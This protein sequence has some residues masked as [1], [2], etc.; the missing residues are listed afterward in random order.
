V[1]LP[2]PRRPV[3]G[4][5]H[6]RANDKPA[7]AEL[8]APDLGGFCADRGDPA[9]PPTGDGTMVGWFNNTASTRTAPDGS[10]AV[11]TGEHR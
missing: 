2:L 7:E 3:R 11:S 8:A 6:R 10:S 5:R 1:G 9:G 4:A